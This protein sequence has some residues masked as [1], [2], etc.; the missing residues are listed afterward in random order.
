V[1][2]REFIGGYRAKMDSGSQPEDVDSTRL[3]LLSSIE[4]QRYWQRTIGTPRATGGRFGT[5]AGSVACKESPFC[6]WQRKLESSRQERNASINTG[7][8]SKSLNLSA[9]WIGNLPFGGARLVVL[10]LNCPG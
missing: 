7:E 4:K 2:T 9:R 6:W 3:H 10:G 1:V 8:R 5:F